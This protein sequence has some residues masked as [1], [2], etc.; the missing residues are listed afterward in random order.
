MN[1]STSAVKTEDADSIVRKVDYPAN[2]DNPLQQLI[3]PRTSG[4]Q[5]EHKEEEI[6]WMIDGILEAVDRE[7]GPLYKACGN[8]IKDQQPV[9]LEMGRK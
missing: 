8:C 3:F 2:Q 7:D 4:Q 9:S 5:C 1:F 6:K